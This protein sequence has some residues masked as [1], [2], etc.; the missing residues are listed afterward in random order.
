MRWISDWALY[1]LALLVLLFFLFPGPRNH[2]PP[3]QPD[4][5]RKDGAM[6]PPASM[7]DEQIVIHVEEPQQGAG[8]AF[9]ITAQ[10]HWLTAA[11]VVAGCDRVS[12]LL[13]QNTY[14]PVE[15]VIVSSESDLALLDVPSVSTD[16]VIIESET[17]MRIGMN[18]FHI[19]YPQG[20]VGEV[21]SQ[22]VRRARLT[23]YG[24][25]TG[26]EGVL[27]WAET[28]RTGGL[29]GSLQGLSGG[30]VFDVQ[31]RVRGVILSQS[32]RRGRIYTAAPEAVSQ[33][34]QAQGLDIRNGVAR[35]FSVDNYGSEADYAR[36]IRQV[37]KVACDLGE[38]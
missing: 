38:D 28:G 35:P 36:R 4:V 14:Y 25:R 13:D 21:A 6:L 20:R 3:P 31:G 33:F 18:G 16:P 34:V 29:S 30:P 8:T 9:A 5:F 10:G 1:L 12:L 32:M 23:S 11:H 15:K 17:D 2:A 22:L 27:V 7:L 37:V 26:R 24:Q 19:G